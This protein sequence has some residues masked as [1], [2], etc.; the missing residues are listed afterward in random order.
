V[1]LHQPHRQTVKKCLAKTIL[2]SQTDVFWLF[3]IQ[4]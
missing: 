1:P 2:L 3:F 4:F